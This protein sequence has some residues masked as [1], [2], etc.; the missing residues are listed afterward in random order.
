MPTRDRRKRHTIISVELLPDDKQRLD[1]IV[2]LAKLVN[3]KITAVKVLRKMI[4]DLHHTLIRAKVLPLPSEPEIFDRTSTMR[5]NG[6]GD[7]PVER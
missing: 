5:G 6:H 3:P 2:R 1:D 7:P 4:G